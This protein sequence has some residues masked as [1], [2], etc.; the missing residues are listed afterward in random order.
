MALWLG[1]NPIL[2]LACVILAGAFVARRRAVANIRDLDLARRVPERATARRPTT[3]TWTLT[4]RAARPAF[5][6]RITD[7]PGGG[8]QPRTVE[9]D[10]AHLAGTTTVQVDT[11]V[12][13]RQRGRVTLRT[14]RVSSRFPLG[15]VRCT[16]APPL[17]DHVLVRPAQGRTGPR[18]R[19]W[20]QQGLEDV[21]RVDA[22]ARAEEELHGVRTWRD[23]DDPRRL[24]A[25]ST[26]RRG[27]PI[28]TEWRGS[29]GHELVLLLGTGGAPAD[30]ERAVSAAATLWRAVL[31]TG[32]PARLVLDRGPG[33]VV[34]RR[35]GNAGRPR[36]R[37]LDELALVARRGRRPRT[38]LA[39][40]GPQRRVSHVYVAS[41]DE[42]R[43]EASLRRAAGRHGRYVVLPAHKPAE[44]AAWVEGLA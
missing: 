1:Q 41:R 43:L 39:A 17:L 24:H 12:A 34:R 40:A 27:E 29:L 7:R 25:G 38:A 21:L 18:W 30:F 22:R 19:R 26:A 37:G 10:V 42:P 13:W 23:G 15:V 11:E 35:E 32:R 14:P 36:E 28:V 8:A 3:V 16:F 2:L 44:L 5:G 9:I 33:G 6:L 31:A 20:L 4:R